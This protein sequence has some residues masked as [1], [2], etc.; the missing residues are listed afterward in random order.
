MYMIIYTN[1]RLYSQALRLRRGGDKTSPRALSS[2]SEVIRTSDS[3]WNTSAAAGAGLLLSSQAPETG[4]SLRTSTVA[5]VVTFIRLL[6][7][8]GF[9]EATRGGAAGSEVSCTTVL[10][11]RLK[12]EVTEPMAVRRD[13]APSENFARGQI[14]HLVRPHSGA[15][16]FPA[17]PRL[18]QLNFLC[19]KRQLQ[20]PALSF[21]TLI[22]FFWFSETNDIKWAASW[23]HHCRPTI[24]DR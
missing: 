22:R 2:V 10:R 20:A 5:A 7:V 17:L 11:E 14:K 12:A 18:W 16:P 23:S 24:G 4:G 8:R 15:P 6:K 19:F 13:L 3:S 1:T 9:L 21:L